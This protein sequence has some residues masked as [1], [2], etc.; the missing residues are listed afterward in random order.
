[1][2]GRLVDRIG[3]RP[4]LAAG[5]VSLL[6]AGVLA[7]AAPA[8]SVAL[9]TLALVLLGFGWNFGLVA[10]TALV[11]DSVPVATRARTQGNVDLA[12][13]LSGASGGISSGFVV[14]AA[15]YA[16]LSIAGGA[17]ALAL[18]PL[19]LLTRPRPGPVAAEA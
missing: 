15:G 17:I 4:V 3:R 18:L 1:V 12:V 11:T 8:S 5:A 16:T 19:L 6:S 14:A 13:S 2:T 10:G 7:A 9:L